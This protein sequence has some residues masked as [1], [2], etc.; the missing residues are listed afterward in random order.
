MHSFIK[1]E[2][3]LYKYQKSLVADLKPIYSDVSSKVKI[4]NAK[5]LKSFENK[6]NKQYH[7]I[8]KSWY[9]NWENLMVLLVIVQKS[10]K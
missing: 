4:S 1:L 5:T 8:T 10:K 2:I 7:Q 9:K 6:W 3:I